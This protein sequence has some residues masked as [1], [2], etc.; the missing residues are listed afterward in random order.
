MNHS[1]KQ[2]HRFFFY[3]ICPEN[4][5]SSGSESHAGKDPA[6]RHLKGGAQPGTVYAAAGS[7]PQQPPLRLTGLHF[8]PLDKPEYM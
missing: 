4:Q 1:L 8:V 3:T 7:P 5:E 2:I 6:S